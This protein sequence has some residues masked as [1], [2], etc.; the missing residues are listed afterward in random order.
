MV[1]I[2]DDVANRKVKM[3]ERLIVMTNSDAIEWKRHPNF[4]R[5]GC[6]G[7]FLAW[8]EQGLSL[9]FEVKVGEACTG[10]NCLSILMRL[11]WW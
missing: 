4:S 3:I 9:F 11:H 8:D 6:A 7:R 10:R 5:L 2:P 1:K